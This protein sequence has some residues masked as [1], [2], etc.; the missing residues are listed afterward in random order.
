MIFYNVRIAGN[1]FF[2]QNLNSLDKL[3]H[4]EDVTRLKKKCGRIT[5]TKVKKNVKAI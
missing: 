3:I 5:K 2:F 4:Q 1:V